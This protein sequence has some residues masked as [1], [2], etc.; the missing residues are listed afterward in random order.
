MKP[1]GRQTKDLLLLA[2]MALALLCPSALFLV[3]ANAPQT[4]TLVVLGLLL[5]AAFRA[6]LARTSRGYVYTILAALAAAVGQHQFLPAEAERFFLLPGEVYCPM[7]LYLA[8]AMTFFEARESVVAT[9]VSLSVLATMI[10]GNV[11]LFEERPSAIP[12]LVGNMV[13]FHRLYGLVVVVQVLAILGSLG[14]ASHQN[15]QDIQPKRGRGSR[16][17]LS[18]LCLGLVA[19]LVSVMYAG[20]YQFQRRFQYAMASFLQRY[21]RTHS[22]RTIFD[23][24]VDL[25]RT[26]GF[27]AAND[28]TVVLRVAANRIPGYLRGYTYTSYAFGRWTSGESLQLQTPL[29]Q[30]QGHITFR[31]YER[32]PDPQA[33]TR[34]DILP[35]PGFRSQVLLLPGDASRIEIIAAGLSLSPDGEVGVEDWERAT[36][37]VVVAPQA[38]VNTAYPGPAGDMLKWNAYLDVPEYLRPDLAQIAE[39]AFAGLP[40]DAST[41]DTVAALRDYLHRTCSYDLGVRMDMQGGDP[42]VQFLT[43]WHRGHCEL[44]AASATLLLRQR[45]IPARYITGFVCA[46]RP[47]GARHYV[48]RRANAHAWAEAY[49]EAT[50]RW[51]LVETTPGDGVPDATTHTSLAGSL[52][53]TLRLAWQRM[54]AM[55]KRGYIAQA[56]V[57][58]FMGLVNC[59]VALFAAPWR[60]AL[61]LAL[62]AGF[63]LWLHRHRRLR[64]Q[65]RILEVGAGRWTLRLSHRRLLK[66]FRKQG[67][68]AAPTDTLRRL[69]NRLAGVKPEQAARLA[70]VVGEYERLRFGPAQPTPSEIRQFDKRLRQTLKERPASG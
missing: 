69:L 22:S 50:G 33:D 59:L 45:G 25:W 15:A 10:A 14:R 3:V 30:T 42:V 21:A 12:Q 55:M 20:A 6:P 48:A 70:A 29:E 56:L 61:T 53:D 62:L 66:H 4:V 60:A 34:L 40:A 7:L 18:A 37:Y 28:Q 49:N 46:E 68:A 64:K 27:R 38:P 58:L 31:V 16:A 65:A 35:A 8:V 13:E 57:S 39:E 63:L 32:F 51:E 26:A 17:V 43:R 41:P 52:L 67:L 19:V 36:G 47:P 1:R 44:F 11:V 23:R 9:V 5:S 24:Q 54:L 2:Y